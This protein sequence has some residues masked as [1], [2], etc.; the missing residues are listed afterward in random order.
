MSPRGS[1][2]K[3]MRLVR[4]SL[5][6]K[7]RILYGLAVLLIIGAALY[8]PWHQ[9]EQLTF[10]RPYAEAQRVAQDYFQYVLGIPR[11]AAD[12]PGPFSSHDAARGP[13]ADAPP[14]AATF[15][16][17]NLLE[18]SETGASPDATFARRALLRFSRAA[19]IDQFYDLH[20]DDGGL[21]LRYATPVRVGDRCLDC[22]GERGS[23]R[24]YAGGELAGVITVSIPAQ[25]PWR[26]LVLNRALIISAGILA[27][28]LAM[29]VFYVITHR[30]I[31]GPVEELRGVARRVTE[32]GTRIRA[33]LR[34]GDE[35]EQLADSF[36]TM[37]ERL[38]ASQEELRTANRSLDVKLGQMAESNVALFEANRVKNEFLANVSHE[39]RTPLAS[40]I[41]FAELLRDSP[42]IEQNTKA[43][44]YAENILISG[45]ILLEIINDLLDLAKIEAGKIE[46]RIEPVHPG[47]V[48]QTM[49]DFLR[50]LSD[51][52]RLTL[53][54]DVPSDLPVIQTDRGR[55]R[56]IL[57]NLIS[58]AIKFTPDEGS[59]R[60]SAHPVAG[61]VRLAVADSGPGIDPSQHALIFEKFR[62]ID[63]SATREHYGTGLGLPIA[64]ELAHLLGGRI[65]VQSELGHGAVFWCEFPV[66]APEPVQDRALV[67]LI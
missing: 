7:Y 14:P 8:L 4:I 24:R 32:G 66:H 15:T 44:R 59:V 63:G 55:L 49:V 52:K 43:S 12:V 35:F 54:C 40:I 19:S 48:C 13:L 47:E 9:I 21:T 26:E 5:A 39:L 57:Y 10:A 36:N 23:A 2:L 58:N 30:F 20:R 28:L 45:R 50:P 31:L 11:G 22:H 18:S 61:G 65:G 60:V 64:R 17:L 38:E 6:A 53:D 46:L 29:L 62:Q 37:L 3:R 25:Q 42:A 16:P 56:Q 33:E 51:K 1:G 27:G 34:T 41:G 67:N